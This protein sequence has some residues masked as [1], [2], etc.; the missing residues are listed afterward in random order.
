MKPSNYTRLGTTIVVAQLVVTS[1][2]ILWVSITDGGFEV[3]AVPVVLA[4]GL[5]ALA[6]GIT[7]R[8][9][10]M[11][12]WLACAAIVVAASPYLYDLLNPS[13]ADPQPSMV[14]GIVLGAPLAVGALLIG[15][16]ARRQETP[17]P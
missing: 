2:I 8:N 14:P 13:A 4:L 3:A 11:W 12:P 9:P 5:V 16:G 1:A 7:Y 15:A 10:R 6:A 17:R